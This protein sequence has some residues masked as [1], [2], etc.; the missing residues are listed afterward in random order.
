[1]KN[2]L[3]KAIRDE[4]Y[5]DS[6]T[7]ANKL[8]VPHK[9]LYNTI[10]KII[11]KQVSGQGHEHA[12]VFSQKF[13]KVTFKNK[14][15]REYPM[16]LINEPAFIK[17][18]MHLSGYAKAEIVQNMFIEAFFTMRNQLIL[19]KTN[20]ANPEWLGRKDQL[21]LGRKEETDVIKSFVEYATK[22]G[23]TKAH[24]YSKHITNATYKAL[25][26]LVQKKPKLRDTMDMYEISELLLMERY[27][28]NKIE[29]YMEL[30]RNYKDIY[31]CVKEDLLSYG[32][33]IKLLVS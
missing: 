7:I 4:G 14:M 24:Y 9:V 23:S 28:K 32:N 22:Q 33:S 27:A 17:L 10:T 8:E 21:L 12:I 30:G 11:S 13:K 3:V 19:E 26:L 18:V 1:M 25:G 5:A 20:A 2:E 31:E 16:Y 6:K 29:Y 15:G